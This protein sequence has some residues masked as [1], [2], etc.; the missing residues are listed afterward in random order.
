MYTVATK[1]Y[2]GPLQKLLELIQ[3]KELEINRVSLT[4]V[5][6]GFL[7]YVA[8]LEH[9]GPDP[10]HA[11]FLS[12]A[13]K[14]ILLKSLS[15]LPQLA[16]TEEENE[17]IRT[18]ENQLQALAYLGTCKGEIGR[19]WKSE[20]PMV[21]REFM[22]NAPRFFVP[23]AVTPSMLAEKAAA[24]APPPETEEPL[25]PAKRHLSIETTMRRILS[26]LEKSSKLSLAPSGASRE[27][28]IVFFLAV[29]HLMKNLKIAVSQDGIFGEI[30]VY[31]K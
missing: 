6:A 9:G 3:K 16:L 21:S 18:L 22:M 26:R 20:A 27:E 12:V 11:E 4:E 24:F 14:L 23:P 1:E 10:E 19:A 2:E 30:T 28:K 15:L 31:S 13:S 5:T 8:K 25:R 17:D 7:E 29:L